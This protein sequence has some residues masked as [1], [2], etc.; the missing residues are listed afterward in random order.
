MER[1]KIGIVGGGQLGRMLTEAALPLGFEVTVIDP[2]DNCPA[3]QAGAEQIQAAL[4]DY[5]AV[6][7]LARKTDVITWEI[8]HIDT[9]ALE[10]IQERSLCAVE[11]SL[12]TLRIIQ[13]KLCQK[14]MLQ[15]AGIPV[16]KFIQLASEQDLTTAF[17][18]F[19]GVIVKT[20][21]GGYDGRGNLVVTSS[22]DWPEIQRQF[23]APLYAEKIEDFQAELAVIIARDTAGNIAQY[24]TV[25]TIHQDNICHTVLA[26]AS[27]D[28]RLQVEAEEIAHETA[29]HLEGVG[30]FAIEMFLTADDK[31]LVNEIAP[32]VHNSGHHTIEANQTSQFEQHIRAITGL[33]LGNTEMVRPAAAMVNIIGDRNGPVDLSGLERVMDLPDTH[34]HLYGKSPTKVARKMGHI[35]VRAN[36]IDEALRLAT[37]ARKEIT[38]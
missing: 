18:Q 14:Q 23:N 19:G 3:A 2:N 8:E 38:V 26:P 32:R 1:Q 37:K 36:T 17:S 10:D 6:L 35:T 34:V 24:P 27:L 29:A 4:T 13:D 33:P 21:T 30:I 5:D 11:P 16:A 31:I 15:K 28:P 20:R 9:K 7:D 22:E 25:Q 12:H